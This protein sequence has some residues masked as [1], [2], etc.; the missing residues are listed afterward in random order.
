MRALRTARTALA[1]VALAPSVDASP[2]ALTAADR[3]ELTA[4]AQRFFEHTRDGDRAPADLY[5][6]R[7]DLRALYGASAAPSGAPAAGDAVVDRQLEALTRDAHD[8]RATFAGGT[9]RGISGAG[10]ARGRVD[11]HRCGRFARADSQC[12]DG[13]LVEYVVGGAARRFQLDTVVRV[14]GHWRVLDIRP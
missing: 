9:F 13:P 1:L 7:D 8:L 2:Y 11:V 5:P 12:A 3:A 6:T 10:Y 4:L 14:R